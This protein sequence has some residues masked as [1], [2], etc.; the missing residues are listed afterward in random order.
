M[1]IGVLYAMEKEAAGL[2]KA[3]GGGEKRTVSGVPVYEC[4]PGLV[5]CVGG[6]GKVNAALAAQLL[7]K[8]HRGLLLEQKPVPARG[9]HRL[10]ADPLRYRGL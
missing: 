6:V 10:P 7:Q 2:L 3:L 8:R 5:I 9:A 4:A 1:H